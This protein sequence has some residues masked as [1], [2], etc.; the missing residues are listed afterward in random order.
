MRNS[1]LGDDG[2]AGAGVWGQ[3]ERSSPAGRP[4]SGPGQWKW[5]LRFRGFRAG[6][7]EGSSSVGPC[8][9]SKCD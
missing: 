9:F 6:T 8:P 3:V 4:P 1:V 2:A 5:A 7:S